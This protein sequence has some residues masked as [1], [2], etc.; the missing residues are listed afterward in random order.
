MVLIMIKIRSQEKIGR[1]QKGFVSF[2]LKFVD[3]K[4][5]EEEIGDLEKKLLK[6]E[7]YLRDDSS[8]E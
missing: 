5:H 6:Y 8:F 3:E 4:L 7:S 2:M 1:S